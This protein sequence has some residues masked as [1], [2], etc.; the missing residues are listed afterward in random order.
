MCLAGVFRREEGG[1]EPRQWRGM[2]RRLD[3]PHRQPWDPTA[4]GGAGTSITARLSFSFVVCAG[5]EWERAQT[6]RHRAD[7]PAETQTDPG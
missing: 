5:I 3:Q 6:D 7:R 4:K 2:G 1:T